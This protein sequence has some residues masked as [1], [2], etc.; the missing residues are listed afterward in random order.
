MEVLRCPH[1]NHWVCFECENYGLWV[2]C[3]KCGEKSRP[4]EL[5]QGH[6]KR[7]R[8]HDK[9]ARLGTGRPKDASTP[10]AQSLTLFLKRYAIPL[11]AFGRLTR[12]SFWAVRQ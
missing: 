3:C 7:G 8:P 10:I 11:R 6:R 4:K 12:I 1:C 9:P 2:K 5:F